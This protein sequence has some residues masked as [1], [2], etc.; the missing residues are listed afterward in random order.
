VVFTLSKHYLT[1]NKPYKLY[2]ILFLSKK[3]KTSTMKLKSLFTLTLIVVSSLTFIF[4][5]CKDDEETLNETGIVS[6]STLEIAEVENATQPLT[7]NVGVS[8]YKHSGGTV[9]VDITGATYGTDYETSTG[10]DSF[11]L[12]VDAGELLTSFSIQP[13]DNTDLDGNKVVTITLSSVS[14][15]LSL[16]DDAT[17]TYTI[18]DDEQPIVADVNFAN[19]TTTINEND[20]TAT[21][22]AITLNVP[23]TSGGTIDV[24]ATGDAVYGTDY[25]VVGQT[26][27]DFTLTV[28]PGAT[29]ASFEIM[30]IDNADF[31]AD[32]VATFTL[33]AVSG[34]LLLGTTT[35]NDVTIVNDDASPT[36][37][38]DF[39]AAN[40]TTIDEGAGTLTVTFDLT[41]A[42]PADSTVELTATGSGVVGNDYTFNGATTSP[43]TFNLLAGATTAT[44]DLPITDDTLIEGDETV[45]LTITNATGGLSVGVTNTTYTFTITDNDFPYAETF[46]SG[47]ALPAGY[48][49]VL[50]NQVVN[51]NKKL[52]F[53]ESGGKYADLND[54][55]ATSDKGVT[56]FYKGSFGTGILDNVL[57]SSAINV[58]DATTVMIDAASFKDSS[59]NAATI[60][61]YYSTTY[62]G[63]GFDLTDWIEMGTETAAALETAGFATG[64]NYKRETFT[65]PA[66]PGPIYVA[67]RVEHDVTNANA[68]IQ[69]RFDNIQ[70]TQ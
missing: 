30:P 20:A 4:T 70:V 31:A 33:S 29:S 52:K 14:G 56:I 11:V 41:A 5:S 23:P 64:P 38:I 43:Y 28:A 51:N 16:G 17:F 61:F 35:I 6:F 39:N 45:T 63:S 62:S 8:T 24:T 42:L 18:F 46:E 65:I 47:T 19:A 2:F 32:K 9:Q 7:V 36:E 50:N 25:T 27:G 66:A 1:L 44:L 49:V 68:K 55:T 69:W 48:A 59:I 60:H 22:L 26:A 15:A 54:V 53:N 58:P 34:D 57:V 12:T 13:I 3:T 40:V 37:L 67:I 10:S 21:A